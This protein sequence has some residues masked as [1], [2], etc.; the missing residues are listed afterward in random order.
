MKV[1]VFT[2]ARCSASDTTPILPGGVFS[3]L[4]GAEE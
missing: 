3:T 4:D 2:G 1:W